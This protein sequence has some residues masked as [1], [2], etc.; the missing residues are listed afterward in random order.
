M[1]AARTQSAFPL[2]VRRSGTSHVVG[3]A[4]AAATLREHTVATS[5][6]KVP[7]ARTDGDVFHSALW[8]A[9][10]LRKA[11]VS[12][13]EGQSERPGLEQGFK[14]TG[15][16]QLLERHCITHLR[17]LPPGVA[18]TAIAPRRSTS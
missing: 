18:P 12:P 11:C 2:F 9:R 4:A 13:C 17:Q 14:S 6:R 1:L 15:D 7:I 8:Y 10:A 5:L 16:R 3:S